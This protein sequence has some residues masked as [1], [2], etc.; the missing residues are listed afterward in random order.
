MAFSFSMLSSSPPFLDSGCAESFCL[1]DCLPVPSLVNEAGT[2]LAL[3]WGS[4]YI[5]LAASF[6]ATKVNARLE[7]SL[8]VFQSSSGLFHLT[9]GIPKI[10]ACN[11]VDQ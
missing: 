6:L 2:Y 7:S 1:R 4:A 3:L 8:L 9:S 11:D 5:C 10:G